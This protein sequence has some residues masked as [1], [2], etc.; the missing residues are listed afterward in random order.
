MTE[1]S[2]FTKPGPAPG[3]VRGA[4]PSSPDAGCEK[5]DVLNHSAS[6]GWLNVGL[7]VMFGRIEVGVI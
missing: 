5:H 6:V 3:S 4:L 2:V 1:K 7:H